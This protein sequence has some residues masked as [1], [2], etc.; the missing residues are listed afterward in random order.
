MD[1]RRRPAEF[2]FG[3]HAMTDRKQKTKEKEPAGWV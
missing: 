2:R 3:V 1:V